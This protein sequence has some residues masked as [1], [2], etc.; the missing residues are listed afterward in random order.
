MERE[1]PRDLSS[2][3]QVAGMLQEFADHQGLS[4]KDRFSL[5]LAI[6][7][8]VTNIIRHQPKSATKIRLRVNGSPERVV[9]TIVDP[10]SVFFD[11]TAARDPKVDLPIED[12]KPGGLGI[13]L[14]KRVMDEVHYEFH[15]GTGTTTLVRRLEP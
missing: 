7:E 3:D 11:P 14:T 4:E 2:L 13:F 12:R 6:E 9:V 5:S 15:D 1:I 8:I 10:D